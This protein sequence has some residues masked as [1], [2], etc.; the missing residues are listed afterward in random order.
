L[1]HYSQFGWDDPIYL[2]YFWPTQI[3]ELEH[4]KI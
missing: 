4:E 1:R 2:P 3:A